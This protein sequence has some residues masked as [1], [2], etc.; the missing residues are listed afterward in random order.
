VLCDKPARARRWDD[1]EPVGAR[2][3]NLEK[4][5]ERGEEKYNELAGAREWNLMGRSPVE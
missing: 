4:A 2:E 5:L 1:H 3:W